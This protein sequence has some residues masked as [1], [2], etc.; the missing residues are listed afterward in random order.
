MV[1][2]TTLN[3]GGMSCGACAQH[4]ARAIEG[5]TG[6]VQVDVDLRAQQARVAHLPESV[7]ESDLVAAVNDA[8]Y[9]ASPTGRDAY[10]DRNQPRSCCCG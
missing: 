8:G 10:T 5:L 9:V 4:V 7:G 2:I 1:T 6:V 3:I